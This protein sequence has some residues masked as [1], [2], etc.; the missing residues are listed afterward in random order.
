MDIVVHLDVN[1]NGKREGAF[2]KKDCLCNYTNIKD[3]LTIKEML[4]IPYGI[5]RYINIVHTNYEYATASAPYTISAE[6]IL[7]H[8]TAVRSAGYV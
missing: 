6:N 1:K 5:Q 2:F 4:T 8:E 3:Y 7:L